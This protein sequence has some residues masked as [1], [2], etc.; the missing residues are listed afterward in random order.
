MIVITQDIIDKYAFETCKAVEN[1]SFYV[2]RIPLAEQ[3]EWLKQ[4]NERVKEQKFYSLEELTV[5]ADN[6]LEN[7]TQRLNLLVKAKDIKKDIA[8]EIIKELRHKKPWAIK[9]ASERPIRQNLEAEVL[10]IVPVINESALDTSV[11]MRLLEVNGKIGRGLV[12]PNKIINEYQEN[13]IKYYWM[14]DVRINEIRYGCPFLTL[15]ETI[16]YAFHNM[17]VLDRYALNPVSSRYKRGRK[18]PQIYLRLAEGY[19]IA[20]WSRYDY[21]VPIT[22]IGVP[23]CAMRLIN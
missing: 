10:P 7:L 16:A 4:I 9:I 17:T 15:S 12:L 19:P 21:F 5:L 2:R 3:L 11:L 8:D 23:S 20:H 13:P 22:E 18:Y 14:V 1:L 6:Q